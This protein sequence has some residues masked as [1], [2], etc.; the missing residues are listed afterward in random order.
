[1]IENQK[2]SHEKASSALTIRYPGVRG[3]FTCLLEGFVAKGTSTKVATEI[4]RE[5]MIDSSSKVI[6]AYFYDVIE[7]IYKDFFITFLRFLHQF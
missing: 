6:S 4:L 3:I 7:R 2:L 1:M 5:I